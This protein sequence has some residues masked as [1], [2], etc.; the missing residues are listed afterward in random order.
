[1]N[2]QGNEKLQDEVYIDEAA[3]IIG[4][5]HTTILRDVRKGKIPVRHR[6]GGMVMKKSAATR[7]MFGR[8]TKGHE[9]SRVVKFTA[10][11]R[12]EP[13]QLEMP[14]VEPMP[15]ED[16][17]AILSKTLGQAGKQIVTKKDI[18]GE[19]ASKLLTIGEYELSSKISLRA[20]EINA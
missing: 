17:V 10:E 13:A 5:S 19:I 1:M 16:R 7:I 9:W 2:V 4:V 3:R 11:E 14:T 18:L 12:F 6:R 20:A 15:S 8:Q